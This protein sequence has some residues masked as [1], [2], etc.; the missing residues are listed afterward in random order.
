MIEGQEVFLKQ[1]FGARYQIMS[2]G[3]MDEIVL[4]ND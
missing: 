1:F 2:W 4:V 3:F